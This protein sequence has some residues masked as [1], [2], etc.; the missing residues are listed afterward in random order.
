MIRLDGSTVV[1]KCDCHHGGHEVTMAKVAGGRLTIIATRYG[2]S[3]N[4]SVGLDTLRNLCYSLVSTGEKDS[5]S[6]AS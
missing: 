5:N 3:H 2:D 1:L 4:V 6:L